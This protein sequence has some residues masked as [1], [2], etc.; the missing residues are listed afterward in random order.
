MVK[1]KEIQPKRITSLKQAKRLMA[2]YIYLFQKKEINDNQL[3]T[4]IYGL[5]KYAEICKAEANIKNSK[6]KSTYEMD[7]PVLDD[8]IQDDASVERTKMS[9]S[10]RYDVLEK[11]N[12]TCQICGAKSPEAVLH[13]D[14]ITPISKGGKTEIDN[15]WVLCQECNLGKSN[16]SPNNLELIRIKQQKAI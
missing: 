12:H 5:I 15:L 1:R 11:Y 14:H 10:L 2:D 3:K 13:V 8:P 4:I 7:V 9:V 16:K 6:N